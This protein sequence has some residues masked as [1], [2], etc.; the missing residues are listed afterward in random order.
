MKKNIGYDDKLAGS[1]GE[2]VTRLCTKI[3]GLKSMEQHDC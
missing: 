2:R 3:K 1:K